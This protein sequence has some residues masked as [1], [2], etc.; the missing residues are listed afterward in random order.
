MNP[1]AIPRPSTP[2]FGYT[3]F[4]NDFASFLCTTPPAYENT[5][6]LAFQQQLLATQQQMEATQQ[7]FMYNLM[8]PP[9]AC[10]NITTVFIARQ[11]P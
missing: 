3:P 8:M 2:T 1:P 5:Q 11:T 4:V 9:P 6:M 10:L 7:Q